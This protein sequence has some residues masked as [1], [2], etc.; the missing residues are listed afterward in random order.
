[1][2][3]RIW[4]AAERQRA[5]QPKGHDTN[6]DYATCRSLPAM[7]FETARAARRPAVSVGEARRRIP[8][9]KLGGDAD[10]TTRLARGLMALGIDPGDRVALVSESRP[11]WVVAD[12]AIMSIG[13]VTRAGLHDQHGRGPPPHPR[14]QRRARGDRLDPGAGRA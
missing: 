12:L 14:Q 3:A 7:F 11:E 1:M 6:M 4:G 13:A 5:R 2:V 9:A 8:A 10:A